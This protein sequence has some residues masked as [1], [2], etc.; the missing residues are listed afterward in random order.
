MSTVSMPTR[1][2]EGRKHLLH[3]VGPLHVAQQDQVEQSPIR[4][5]PT[6]PAAGPARTTRRRGP[7]SGQVGATMNS[8]PCARLMKFISPNTTDTRSTAKEQRRRAAAVERLDD[9]EPGIEEHGYPRA[10]YQVQQV[11]GIGAVNVRGERI[12]PW[13]ATARSRWAGPGRRRPCPGPPPRRRR[14][15]PDLED[16][17]VLDH[18][19]G[20]RIDAERSAGAVEADVAHRR[21]QGR[22]VLG[23]A[24][25]GIEGLDD[26]TGAVVGG[27]PEFGSVT[28][29]RGAELLLETWSQAC[30]RGTC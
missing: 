6:G 7:R 20:C 18:V 28:S 14:L 1:S 15:G 4:A 2:G 16:V 24:A 11:H 9:Q 23:V 25:G 3:G 13:S 12:S 30:D 8:V 27:H 5:T 17:D 29:V 21:D 19:V 26:E 22:L 10:N